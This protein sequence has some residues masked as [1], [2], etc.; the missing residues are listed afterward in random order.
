MIRRSIFIRVALAAALLALCGNAQFAN[1]VDVLLNGGFEDSAGPANWTLTQT[2]TFPVLPLGTTTET[3]LLTAPIMSFIGTAG[4]FKTKFRQP[5][6]A[7]SR[8]R[9]MMPGAPGL[10]MEE[11]ARRQSGRPSTWTRPIIRWA[12]RAN[13]DCYSAFCR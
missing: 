4:P 11:V 9:I 6:R 1:A 13:S 3:A 5:R 8:P 2:V 10:E 12:L 7:R